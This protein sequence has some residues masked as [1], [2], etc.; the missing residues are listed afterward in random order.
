MT[1]K[2]EDHVYCDRCE[3]DMG[4]SSKW[5][6]EFA[7]GWRWS[8]LPGHY[9]SRLCYRCQKE[10]IDKYY[11]QT[12]S[13]SYCLNFIGSKIIDNVILPFTILTISLYMVYVLIRTAL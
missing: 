9:Q 3:I 12:Q 7:P 5:A 10:E 4:E 1:N 2:E 13:T 8:S 6:K 11:Y